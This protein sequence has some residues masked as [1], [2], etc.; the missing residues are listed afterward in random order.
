MDLRRRPEVVI[1]GHSAGV[2]PGNDAL[3]RC[4]AFSGYSQ[5]KAAVGS[6]FV[7]RRAGM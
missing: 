7:A 6:I 2:T 4:C 1:A 5:R 3:G